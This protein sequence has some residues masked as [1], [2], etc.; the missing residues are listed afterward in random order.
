ME[1]I[2]VATKLVDDF[3]CHFS[4]LE[5]IHSDQG[6][7][8]ESNI[9]AEICKLLKISKTRTTPYHLQSDGLVERYNRTLVSMLV[10]CAEEHPFS[11]E[12]YVKK[13]CMA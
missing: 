1:A 12:E 9:I 8:F 2:T 7:Q 5:Q 11:W 4:I 3:F 6:K 10:M 13:M